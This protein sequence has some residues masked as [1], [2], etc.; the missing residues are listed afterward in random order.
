M[1][2]EFYQYFD[3]PN[4]LEH[5]KKLLA[6]RELKMANIVTDNQ[7]WAALNYDE[8]SMDLKDV[9]EDYAQL[10]LYIKQII[11][12]S[13]PPTDLNSTDMNDPKTIYIH[14]D[15][16]DDNEH[17]L[18]DS[19]PTLFS[20]KYVLNIPLVNCE[21]S[22]TFFYD[23]IDPNKQTK[24]THIH[25]GGCVDYSNVVEVDKFT[26][27]KP[28]FLKV[29]V[30]HAVHNPTDSLR[31]VCSMRVDDSSPLLKRIFK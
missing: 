7:S 28:A 16:K 1:S 19:A 9:I 10:G 12:I 22:T 2:S 30:P 21:N 17:L 27:N 13:F 8:F 11:F 24:S 6:Y 25:F 14:V 4:W 29:S 3:Y 18:K 20:P 15:S 26:L 5:Q 31:I 23:F